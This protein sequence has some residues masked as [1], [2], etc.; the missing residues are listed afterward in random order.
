MRIINNEVYY[1]DTDIVLVS[2]K[3]IDGLKLLASANS[4]ERV[5]LCAHRD[6][7]DEIHEMLIVIGKDNYIR[8][9]RHLNKSETFHVIEGTADIL[10]FTDEGEL[11]EIVEM[12]D[13]NSNRHFFF[14]IDRPIYHSM[15]IKSDVFIFHETTNGP[16]DRND[17]LLAP[18]SPE[19]SC[20]EAGR[21]FLKQTISQMENKN[22]A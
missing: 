19:E 10:L 4:R 6:I 5:R 9:H 8:P 1:P 14:R 13:Y 15:V 18:W 12:G 7:S 2:R 20:V 17:M 22:A 11:Q 3:D 21:A 16:F